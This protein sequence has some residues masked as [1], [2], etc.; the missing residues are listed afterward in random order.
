MAI[1]VIQRSTINT[2]AVLDENQSLLLGGLM[3]SEQRSRRRGIPGLMNIP[4]VGFLFASTTT[5]TI[6][7]QRYILLKP[8]IVELPSLNCSPLAVPGPQSHIGFIQGMQDCM[9]VNPHNPGDGQS[10]IIKIA[11]SV[12]GVPSTPAGSPNGTS[13]PSYPG[14]VSPEQIS[15]P[16]GQMLQRPNQPDQPVQAQYLQVPGGMTPSVTT[17]QSAPMWELLCR[18]RYLLRYLLRCLLSS[19]PILQR[20]LLEAAN[21]WKHPTV[22]DEKGLNMNWDFNKDRRRIAQA[23]LVMAIAPVTNLCAQPPIVDMGTDFAADNEA[24][25]VAKNTLWFAR[26]KKAV[27]SVQVVSIQH[28]DAG[29]IAPQLFD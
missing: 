17:L 27:T 29:P 20:V 14:Q 26:G 2:Q 28:T 3:R 24:L 23:F 12:P 7:T 19:C 9:P 8:R 6:K 22:S 25:Y 21:S 13:A 16:V 1:P 5:S 4:K 15:P 18:L 10:G 11:P